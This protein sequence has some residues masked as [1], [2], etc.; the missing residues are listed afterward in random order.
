MNIKPTFCKFN[1]FFR[2]QMYNY[3][4]KFPFDGDLTDDDLNDIDN[5]YAGC[6]FE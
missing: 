4:H 2:R 3:F 1:H 5:M 6:A